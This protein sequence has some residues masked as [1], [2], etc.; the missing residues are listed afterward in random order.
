MLPSSAIYLDS[1]PSWK[2]SEYKQQKQ[3][4][5]EMSI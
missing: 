1:K 3:K 5:N 4:Q 2:K